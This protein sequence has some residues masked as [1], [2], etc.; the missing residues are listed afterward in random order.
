MH[1]Y[2]PEAIV[3]S[4]NEQMMRIRLINGSQI[5]ILGSDNFDNSLVGTNAVGMIFSEYALQ[6]P[7]AWS[8]SIPILKASSGWALFCSTVR[9]RNHFYDLY[10]AV[11]DHEDWFC[12]KL[13]IEDTLHISI[14][15]I[16]KEISSGQMSRDLALQEFWNDFHLGVEGSYYGKYI[17]DLRRKG[18][19]TNVLWEPYL[20]VHTA[21]DLGYNDPTVIAFFQVHNN[22]IRIIDFYQNN[23]HGLEHYAKIIKSKDYVYGKHIAPFDIGV[24]DLS[25]GIS[26]WK[27]M[28]DLG[29]SFIR[30]TE[31]APSIDDGIEIVRRSLPRMWIDEKT[32]EPLIKAMEN[33][34]QEYDNKKKVYK[35][36]PLHDEN[37]HVCFVGE[38]KIKMFVGYKNIDQ[39]VVGDLVKTPFGDRKVLGV[40]V[41]TSRS[42]CEIK[43]EDYELH[44]TPNHKV[45]ST[46]G[47]VRSDMLRYLSVLDIYNPMGNVLWKMTK[48]FI[49]RDMSSFGFKGTFSKLR[50]SLGYS[51]MERCIN[52]MVVITLGRI[53]GELPIEFIGTFG[54]SIVEKYRKIIT[55][56]MSIMIEKTIKSAI[57][58]CYHHLRICLCTQ[59]T[60]MAG[61]NQ[62]NVESCC[63]KSGEKQRFGIK[64]MRAINGT[65]K[66]LIGYYHRLEGLSMIKF[67]MCAQFISRVMLNSSVSVLMSASRL[68]VEIVKL[69]LL[70]AFA[71]FVRIILGVTSIFQQKTVVKSVR[72]YR[73]QELKK[74]Y[75]LTVD[76]DGCYY[77]NNILVSNCDMIR[78]LC[79]A[80]PRVTQGSTGEDV[81]K[82]YNQAMYGSEKLGG[83]FNDIGGY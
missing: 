18:Q 58:K 66:M 37:S 3:E 21:W 16:E 64:A 45:F 44:C 2:I 68:F 15:E 12:E 4:R 11:K 74:V 60:T 41:R 7:R 75:D 54:N 62:I 69:I 67:V 63:Q 83:F 30:Y 76:I 55:F 13:T 38:T 28:H 14:E 50:M 6:D 42:F 77:A 24:H 46:D 53:I 57:F 56:I 29:I 82:R 39:I 71:L 23:K 36:Q 47:I 10:N 70:I 49:T 34:R 72:I 59:A 17:D 65:G 8:F 81:N 80:L 31:K 33:Y 19:I 40:N 5:Q 78:Y 79:V 9:G 26:R 52:G 22:Q 20:P 61:Q 1:H 25:T 43:T 48:L 73:S 35:S 32:C 51:L 27:M